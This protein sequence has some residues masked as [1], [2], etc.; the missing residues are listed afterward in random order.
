MSLINE[1]YDVLNCK[2]TS[3]CF[4][5]EKDINS[6]NKLISNYNNELNLKMKNNIKIVNDILDVIIN[7]DEFIEITIY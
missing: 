5:D 2:I 4:I 1:L 6:I 3:G 7:E